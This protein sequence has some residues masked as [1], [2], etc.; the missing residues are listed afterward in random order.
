M[1][2][3]TILWSAEILAEGQMSVG[4]YLIKKSYKD[5][6]NQ[7]HLYYEVTKFGCGFVKYPKYE[8]MELPLEEGRIS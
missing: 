4:D 7:E 3:T 2:L 1:I 5:A 6:D 8:Q